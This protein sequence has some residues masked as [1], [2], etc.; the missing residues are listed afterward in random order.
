[1]DHMG[2]DILPPCCREC[3]AE[4]WVTGVIVPRKL[5]FG[6]DV[7]I[8]EDDGSVI[9]LFWGSA[10]T[11]VV[12]WNKRFTIGGRW[13]NSPDQGLLACGGADAVIPL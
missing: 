3:A 13:F 8:R 5:E 12:E 11:A 10:N 4:V 1:M 9:P 2:R 6:V 7:T